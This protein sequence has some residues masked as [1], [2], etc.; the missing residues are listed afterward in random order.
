MG[1][2]DKYIF[3]VVILLYWIEVEQEGKRIYFFYV[4]F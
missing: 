4:L 1:I 2:D 3:N